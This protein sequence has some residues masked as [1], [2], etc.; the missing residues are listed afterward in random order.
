MPEGHTLYRLAKEQSELFAGRPVHVTSPQGRF[1][2]GAEL[3]DGRVLEEVTSFGKHLFACFGADTLHVHLGLY[4]SYAA[5]TGIPPAQRVRAQP[6]EDELHLA[7]GDQVAGGGAAQVGPHAFA[8]LARAL[9]AHPQR[10]PRR[11]RQPGAGGERPVEPQVH[12]DHV[13]AEAGEQVLAVGGDV[14]EHPTVQ[15]LGL[16]GEAALRAGHVH[17]AAGER[18][19]LLAGQAEQGVALRHGHP[20][21]GCT[22]RG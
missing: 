5:G 18:G 8:V 1:A 6:V 14:V 21:P 10:T 2:A 13:R 12:V 11:G 9:P 20:A 17:L 15:Q 7:V 16:A 19:L 3:L 22:G 4:G